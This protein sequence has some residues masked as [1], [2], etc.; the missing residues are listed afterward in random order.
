MPAIADLVG[1]SADDLLAPARGEGCGR[2]RSRSTA[3]TTADRSRY[4]D[5]RDAAAC[6]G[7]ARACAPGMGCGAR[8]GCGGWRG[9]GGDGWDRGVEDRD[10]CGGDDRGRHVGGTA[11]ARI[12]GIS[13]AAPT[14]DPR[15]S[16]DR[17]ARDRRDRTLLRR[18]ACATPAH[19]H[20]ASHQVPEPPPPTNTL[21]DESL[22]ARAR[23]PA[24]RDVIQRSRLDD[25]TKHFATAR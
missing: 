3:R 17:G 16:S 12:A 1:E 11:C 21:A 4:G 8:E 24:H 14:S 9:R 15:G 2:E 7:G 19:A 20:L 10:C 18:S 22:R 25:Y 6:T 5:R 13:M 23:D